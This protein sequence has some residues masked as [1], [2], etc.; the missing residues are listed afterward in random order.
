MALSKKDKEFRTDKTTYV[1]FKHLEMDRVLTMLFPMLKYDGYGSRLRENRVWTVDDFLNIF[2]E[3][4]EW[5]QGFD[6]EKE[7]V[8]RWIE[9]DLLD[10]VNR[11]KP[12]QTVAAPRPLHGNTYKF[13]NAGQCKDYGVS[14]QIYWMLHHARHDRGRAALEA[15][16]AFFFAGYDITTDQYTN[17]QHVDVETQA[18][19]R[20]DQQVKQDARESKK[21]TRFPPLCIGQADLMA[22]DILRL[23]AYESQIPR[24]V[25]VEY[26]KTLLGFHLAIYHLK[27]FQLLPDMVRRRGAHPLCEACR[28]DPDTAD[29]TEKCP[30]H[31]AMIVDIGECDN[32]R[33]K[34]LAERSAEYHYQQFIYFIQANFIVKKLD[35]MAEYMNKK[36]KE[37]TKYPSV[38]TLLE[39]LDTKYDMERRAYFQRRLATILEQGD[40]DDDIDVEIRNI[41]NMELDEFNTFIEIMMAY[42]GEYNRRFITR[43]LDSLMFK[44]R[45]NGLLAQ[46]STN[47]NL[48][49]FVL[50]SKLLEVLLQLS[51]L[52][53]ENGRYVTRAI[54]IEELLDFLR[55][56]YGLHIDRFPEKHASNQN[57]MD[58]RALRLNSAAFK[59]R[60]YEI[61]FYEDLSDAYVTQKIM[62]RY[63]IE[64]VSEAGQ[65]GEML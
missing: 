2:L 57:I 38:D 65:A 13:R 45:D 48:R 56:R 27:L 49:R 30:Y 4:Q 46:S 20:L 29:V 37:K 21:P 28:I 11:G 53:R 16:R 14:E 32:Q 25:L 44:N 34:E 3:H 40:V 6:T 10:L 60:L 22:D 5:F 19:L 59:R 52:T 26:L 8:Y 17:S 39:L 42:R 64:A 15:L 9:T 61:G 7:I 50:G 54:R 63:S 36:N 23:L 41:V 51:V 1:D 31:I 47:E 33:M 24:S 18:L 43:C 62:P 35:E 12:T 58:R 55:H